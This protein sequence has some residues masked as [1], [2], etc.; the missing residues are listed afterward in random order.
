[1]EELRSSLDLLDDPS[2]P[3]DDDDNGHGDDFEY[4]HEED[5]DNSSF[6]TARGSL[7]SVEGVDNDSFRT[8]RGSPSSEGG[9]DRIQLRN[10]RQ[11]S[12]RATFLKVDDD[13]DEGPSSD[14]LKNNN[15]DPLTTSADDI[16]VSRHSLDYIS[17]VESPSGTKAPSFHSVDF[18]RHWSSIRTSMITHPSAVSPH[19]MA[20]NAAIS[21]RDDFVNDLTP[22]LREDY[23]NRDVV[24]P[25][26]TNEII[27]GRMLGSG[28]F[29]HVYEIS[30][31]RPMDADG[32]CEM[33]IAAR[34][35]MKARERYRDTNRCTYAV[36]HLR[37]T[38]LERYT[39]AQYVQAARDVALEAIFLNSLSDPNII[40]LRG[41]SVAGPGGF[42][43][44]EFRVFARGPRN[45]SG[46]SF[47]FR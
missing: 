36:K 19:D 4:N 38:L 14:L 2:T 22:S 35:R 46:E 13:D 1:M 32:L 11:S 27:L 44:G 18:S 15:V 3:Y 33:E 29:S 5:I 40:K 21:V 17:E 39:D 47:F 20:A 10:I 6:R 25:F 43:Q 41:I 37:P 12:L 9:G 34:R 28:E 30:K 8:S 45:G 23:D 24:A 7:L 26:R 16:S 42:T 31:F